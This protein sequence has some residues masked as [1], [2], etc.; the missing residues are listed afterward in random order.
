MDRF[1]FLNHFY[2][3]SLKTLFSTTVNRALFI[4]FLTPKF[5]EQKSSTSFRKGGREVSTFFLF[6]FFFLSYSKLYVFFNVDNLFAY[7]HNC[8][9]LEHGMAIVHKEYMH[10]KG[11]FIVSCFWFLIMISCIY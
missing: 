5:K 6:L 2:L 10:V 3:K 7:R 11:L 9:N 8:M 4:I 1:F